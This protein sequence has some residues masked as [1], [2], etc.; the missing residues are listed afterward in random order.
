MPTVKQLINAYALFEKNIYETKICRM[1]QP[2]LTAVV[3]NCEKRRLGSGGGFGYQAMYADLD[4]T[5][6]DAVILA[7]WAIEEFPEPRTQ[8]VYY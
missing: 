7:A 2:A 3:T 5:M 1:D 8:K 4:D 6:M